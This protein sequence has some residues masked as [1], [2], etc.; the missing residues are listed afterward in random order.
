MTKIFIDGLSTF[1]P[2]KYAIGHQRLP[3]GSLRTRSFAR[4]KTLIDNM[5]SDAP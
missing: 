5:D 4:I 2:L 1:R 3:A